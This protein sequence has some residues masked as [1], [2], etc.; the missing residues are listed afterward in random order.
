MAV[1]KMRAATASYFGE[2]RELR[3]EDGGER[4]KAPHTQP[5][6]SQIPNPHHRGI[7][8]KPG[9]G[10]DLGQRRGEQ[11]RF[12]NT[13]GGSRRQEEVS[14]APARSVEWDLQPPAAPQEPQGGATAAWLPAW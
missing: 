3:E 4:A 13:A 5:P 12:K 1:L 14:T 7:L 11:R 9:N 2:G 8:W 6:S 10:A